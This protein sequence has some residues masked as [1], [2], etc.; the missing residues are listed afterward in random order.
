M[1]ARIESHTTGG[2]VL[3]SEDTKN[4][5]GDILNI[6]DVLEVMQKGITTPIDIYDVI[7]IEGNHRLQL[8]NNEV[9][10]T[11]L[12]NEIRVQFNI[13]KGNDIEDGFHTGVLTHFGNDNK[14]AQIMSESELPMYTNIVI[15]IRHHDGS[16]T[17]EKLYA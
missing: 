10:Y 9:K 16:F 7:G 12:A 4:D 8:E 2:M 14:Q 11:E 5:V 1:A 17:E 6:K 15:G 13:I 3:I